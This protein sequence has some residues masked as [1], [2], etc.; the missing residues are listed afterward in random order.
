MRPLE[1]DFRVWFERKKRTLLWKI[2]FELD[3]F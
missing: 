1:I 3:G 2:V